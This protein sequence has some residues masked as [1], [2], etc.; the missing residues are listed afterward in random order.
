VLKEQPVDPDATTFTL[1]RHQ[2]SA[3]VVAARRLPLESALLRRAFAAE[4]PFAHELASRARATGSAHMTALVERGRARG[5]LRA[6]IDAALQAFLLQ[7]LATKLG[8][9][10]ESKTAEE[11]ERVFD[12]VVAVLR[13]GMSPRPGSPTSAR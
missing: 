5:E 10:L 12:Q 6:D 8:P 9:A 1:L 7:A 11:V 3:T 13:E 2:M 4:V